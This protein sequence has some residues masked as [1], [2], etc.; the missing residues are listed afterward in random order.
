[1]P[2]L[3]LTIRLLGPPQI[4][5]R[6][7]HH[8]LER[9]A[10]GLLAY[11]AMHGESARNTLAALLWPD[12]EPDGARNNLR[13]T[14]FKLRRAADRDLIVGATH[15]RVAPEV[16]VDAMESLPPDGQL[17][18]GCE[19]ADCPE[20]AD[21][22]DA[23]RTRLDRLRL[24]AAAA[25][26]AALENAGQ[27]DAALR[28]AEDVVRRRPL[29]E[30]GHRRVIR[31]HYLRGDRAAALAAY[32]QCVERLRRELDVSPSEET[33]ALA[34]SIETGLAAMPKPARA[35]VPVTL[36]RPPRLIGRE[37]EL[38]ALDRAWQE[39]RA[40]VVV[41][42]PGLG[43][44]RVLAEFA[45][46]RHGILVTAARPGD[47]AI[48]YASLA[49]IL[50]SA[51]ERIP[52]LVDGA[53]RDELSRL[54][55][56][57]GSGRG[58]SMEGRRLDL[59][60]ALV[61]LLS[62]A[63]A[64]GVS[65]VI[66]DDLHFAD[67]ASVE[68]LQS[69]AV[70]DGLDRLCWGFAQRPAEGG[71]A[72]RSLR[73][74]LGEAS[75]LVE[76]ALTP[77]DAAQMAKLVDCLAIPGLEGELVAEQL[78]KFTGGNPL[79]ALET[80]KDAL[81]AGASQ[82]Q[83][84]EGRLPRPLN[85]GALID[86]RLRQLSPG[87]LALARVAAIAG[88]DFG[89]ELAAHVLQT[90]ELALADAWNELEAGQVLKGAAF[91]HD[92]V[93]ESALRSVPAPI[94]QQTHR[95]IALFLETRGG[96]PARLAEHWTAAGEAA[97]AV[98]HFKA[99]AVRAEAAA[100]FGEARSLLER[101]IAIT[102][103]ARLKS[104]TLELQFLLVELLKDIG[105]PGETLA[106]I[107]RMRGNVGTADERMRL[108]RSE[109]EALAYLG[110]YPEAEATAR[111]ALDDADCVEDA[112]PLRVAEVRHALA[113]NL[114]VNRRVPEALELL[115]LV[116]MPLRN[117]PDLQFR[118]WFHSDY[119]RALLLCDRLAQ[120]DQHLD[121]GLEFARQ[122]GRQRMICGMV[123]MKGQVAAA[124]GLIHE[125]VE[126][127]HE[128]QLAIADLEPSVIT[129]VLQY[130]LAASLTDAGRYREALAAIEGVLATP[131]QTDDSWH[132][133]AH[134]LRALIYGRLGER[135]LA[136][137][138]RADADRFASLP[139]SIPEKVVTRFELDW[140][141]EAPLGETIEHG[142]AELAKIGTPS[143]HWRFALAQ[144][145]AQPEAIDAAAMESLH[146]NATGH[147][148]LGHAMAARLAMALAARRRGD[149]SACVEN[150]RTVLQAMRR[151]TLPG[152]YRPRLWLICHELLRELD[153]AL[154]GR[155]LRDGVDWIHA[156]AR[157][158]VP[159]SFRDGFLHRNPVNRSMLVAAERSAANG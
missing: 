10:A 57:L 107:E 92:L 148:L 103:A 112:D 9:K 64:W 37:R 65:A 62:A 90:N 51:I 58:R 82:A 158:H 6:S 27:L 8:A 63:I 77:L 109:A 153:P 13:Q 145:L 142:R 99:A 39:E 50:R 87:A 80:L 114:L 94:A 32:E 137:R 155:A 104:A 48:P 53:S 3:P 143:V 106:V 55:P 126:R 117:H 111:R 78:V 133:R 88:P 61:T 15:L 72:A 67:E 121:A 138:C 100:R 157:F 128:A 154:A 34:A 46:D 139:M 16:A 91:A 115:A 130:W 49:R 52:M 30:L 18:E 17:L 132:E 95:R 156:V 11:L 20:F 96:E 134:G 41:G 40:F 141:L 159:E 38:D 97:R 4:A 69:L 54:L 36:L 79:F 2:D 35:V 84:R 76:V 33:R 120:A 124:A 136:A 118:G 89:A 66:V 125:P 113:E 1:L 131:A 123:A 144:A 42:E 12:A 73:E 116:E 119:A 98:P 71:Q 7:R 5:I 149:A 28:V 83:L 22:L 81:A 19:Y 45:A 110:K 68:M 151:Y 47:S 14:L 56:E 140:I 122:V 75:A 26:A 127:F 29:E 23:E 105:A 135:G 102:E 150:A 60:R 146:R 101:A 152:S 129:M 86:R 31:L 44:S 21:W 147:G 59:Q 108:T 70:A 93:F 43:K 25:N 74:A 24:D 85:V